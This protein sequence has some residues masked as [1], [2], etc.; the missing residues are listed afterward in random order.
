M[1]ILQVDQ[2]IARQELPVSLGLVASQVPGVEMATLVKA[3][4]GATA[5]PRAEEVSISPAGP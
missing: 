1:P 2:S 5:D 3:A 4:R